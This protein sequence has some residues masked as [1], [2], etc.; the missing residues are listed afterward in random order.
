MPSFLSGAALAL[1]T[2]LSLSPLRRNPLLTIG[3]AAGRAIGYALAAASTRLPG[4]PRAARARQL[5]FAS[6][7]R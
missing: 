3:L 7:W 2:A 4:S 1:A 5:T 6:R